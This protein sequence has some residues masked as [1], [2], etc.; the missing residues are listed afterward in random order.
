MS[1]FVRFGVKEEEFMEMTPR[2]LSLLF[3]ENYKYNSENVRSDWERTRLQI[4][5]GLEFKN[6]V[7]YKQF[8]IQYMPFEWDK[9][10]IIEDIPQEIVEQ[11]FAQTNNVVK[12]EE[13]SDISQ[14]KGL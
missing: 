5:Y 11:M 8:C 3:E 14:I 4:Y 7:Q 6:P 1:V 2:K 10:E 12:S 9:K 13:L